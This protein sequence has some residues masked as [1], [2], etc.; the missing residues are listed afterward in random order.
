MGPVGPI[1]WRGVSGSSRDSFR[2]YQP[3]REL[4]G[5]LETDQTGGWLDLETAVK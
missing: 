2:G 3:G 1:S 4:P 5:M